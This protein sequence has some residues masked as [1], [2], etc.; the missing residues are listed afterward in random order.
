MSTLVAAVGRFQMDA[1]ARATLEAA[2]A[3]RDAGG[4]GVAYCYGNRLETIRSA[5]PC[6]HMPGRCIACRTDGEAACA[7]AVRVDASARGL[8]PVPLTWCRPHASASLVADGVPLPALR[9]FWAA[10]IR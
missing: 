2:G 6:A 5:L 8:W 1:L 7:C 9:A 10:A 4:W 3:D